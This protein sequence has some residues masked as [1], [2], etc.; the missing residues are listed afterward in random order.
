MRPTSRERLA[1]AAGFWAGEGC[2]WSGSSNSKGYRYKQR[3]IVGRIS[4]VDKRPLV[5]FKRAVSLGS[6]RGPY[7]TSKGRPAYQWGVS[8]WPS[9]EKLFKLLGP[10]LDPVK[11]EQFI[12]ARKLYRSLASKEARGLR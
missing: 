9:I 7:R 8:G 2:C 12:A 3:S 6:I 10:W 11:R 4:Q 5:R 1:W